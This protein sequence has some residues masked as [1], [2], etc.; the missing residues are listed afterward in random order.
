MWLFNSLTTDLWPPASSLIPQHPAGQAQR[1]SISL[2]EAIRTKKGQ[3]RGNKGCRNEEEGY[4]TGGKGSAE[5]LARALQSKFPSSA[6]CSHGS[7][8][9]R[10]ELSAGRDFPGKAESVSIGLEL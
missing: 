7:L 1:L 8:P 2:K 6:S 4:D 5:Q 3:A 10:K 9:D